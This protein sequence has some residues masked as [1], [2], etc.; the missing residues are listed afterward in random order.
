MTA[1]GATYGTLP[2]NES[3]EKALPHLEKAM[4]LDP[5]LPE[6]LG[7]YGLTLEINHGNGYVTRYAHTGEVGVEE[8]DKVTKGQTVAT[9]GSSGRATGPH[10]HFEVYKDSRSVN[11][12]K[13]LQAA[14]KQ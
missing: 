14:A 13:Y 5:E 10:L 8:G 12:S 11:P 9:I 1:S 7:A 4:E 3:L 6:A 2:L